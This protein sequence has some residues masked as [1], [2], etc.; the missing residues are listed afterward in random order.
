[1][2]K[3]TKEILEPLVRDSKSV[4]EVCRKLNLKPTGGTSC[5]ISKLIKEKF[6]I[7]CS[8][9][10]GRGSNRGD[11]HKGGAKKRSCEELLVLRDKTQGRQKPYILRRALI[12][13]GREYKCEGC[14]NTGT[15]Q[16]REL[17]LQVDHRNCEWWDDSP[18][19]VRFMCPNCHSQTEGYSGSVG[20][21][22][23]TSSSACK[24]I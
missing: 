12:E 18:G 2:S 19:N 17:R 11:S 7:G 5:Y 8:H 23:L 9:F 1:M 13:S 14:G 16:G 22:K 20:N 21:T 3:Y 15:W 10:T 4:S 24:V 6:Q